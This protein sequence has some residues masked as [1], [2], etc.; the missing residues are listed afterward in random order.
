[1]KSTFTINPDITENTERSIVKV[2]AL[3]IN[4]KVGVLLDHSVSPTFCFNSSFSKVFTSIPSR[5]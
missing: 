3:F 5:E 2:Q 4:L 1:M